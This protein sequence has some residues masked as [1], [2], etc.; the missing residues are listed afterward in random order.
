ME[1]IKYN[2]SLS[3]LNDLI[4]LQPGQTLQV[5]FELENSPEIMGHF[6]DSLGGCDCCGLGNQSVTYYRII[7]IPQDMPIDK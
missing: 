1:W 7:Q 5:I 6:N 4:V 3:A 2:N